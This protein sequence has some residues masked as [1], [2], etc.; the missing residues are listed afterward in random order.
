MQY[1]W[2][3]LHGQVL[4]VERELTA[5]GER[6]YVIALD[7]ESLTHFFGTAWVTLWN[8]VESLPQVIQRGGGVRSLPCD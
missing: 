5:D 7:D 4:E 8:T 1:P 6:V 3:A 2:H